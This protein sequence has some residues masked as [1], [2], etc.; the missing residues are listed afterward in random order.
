MSSR[1]A[2][3]VASVVHA[4]LAR[5]LREDVKDPAIG[6]VSLT[7][8][9]VNP[10]LTV[11]RVRYLP[12]GGVGDRAAI[13]AGLERAARM[14]R[15]HIGRAL[16]IRHAPELRFELDRNVEYAAH[17][18]E[19]FKRLPTPAETAADGS[20]APAQEGGEE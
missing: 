8:V 18:D 2:E 14:L 10:D 20:A 12:L 11:A 4:E 16:Q 15:G 6:V 9:T 17:M 5:M 1:R 19:I 7:G 13:Q 3:R